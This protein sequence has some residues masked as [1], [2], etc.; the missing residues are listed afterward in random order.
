MLQMCPVEVSIP[1]KIIFEK[2]L[3]SGN[4][5]SGWKLANIQP[6]HKKASRQI[7]SNY[8]PIS[9][10]PVC[11][12]VFE[13]IIFDDLYKFLNENNLISSLQS[14]F[15]PGDS[16]I[17]QLLSITTEIYEAFENFE[18]VRAAFLDISKAFDKVWHEGLLFKL[19]QN[20]I[21]GNLYGFMESYLSDRKQRVVLN[22]LESD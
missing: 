8:R 19:K 1:L 14:G 2:S 21:S 16:T 13:K 20:G 10:L 4:F 3:I 22:G 6:I 7:K 17:N 9:L 11:S 18:E 5:P 15:R 12:K